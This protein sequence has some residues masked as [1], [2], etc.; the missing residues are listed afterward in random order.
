MREIPILFSTPMVQAILDGRKTMTRRAV[1]AMSMQDFLTPDLISSAPK[2]ELV[3]NWIQLHHPKGG[4]LTCIKC[5]YG[6]PGD[7]LWVRETWQHTK[8]L[9]LNIEDE[10]YGYVYKA[11]GQPWEDFEGWTW[12]PSIHMPKEACRIRLKVTDVK[13]ERLQDISEADAIAEGIERVAHYG[14]TGY[15]LYTEPDAAY[16]DIDAVYSFESLW[17]SINGKESWEQNPWVWVVKFERIQS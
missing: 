6:Q 5:P 8:V 14:T 1:K 3:G 12:K 16:S 2:C 7:I 11:D 17:Q 15:M 13:V 4:P 10:N 9:G